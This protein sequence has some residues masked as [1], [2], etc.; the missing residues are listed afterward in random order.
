MKRI[1]TILLAALV[2]ASAVPAPAVASH[3]DET[4]SLLNDVVSSD[5][6]RLDAMM[7]MAAGMYQRTQHFFAARGDDESPSQ[8]ADN[9]KS[10][11][12][13]NSASIQTYVNDRTDASTGSDVLK[14][15]LTEGDEGSATVYL[16]A[17]VNG[18][19][20][21]NSS[22]VDSTARTV[23]EECTLEGAAA[24]NADDELETFVSTFVETGDDASKR[25]KSELAAEY[26]GQ[27]SCSFLG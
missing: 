12:N 26:A 7:G 1:T 6:D 11:F 14:L 18:S 4:E 3:E 22:I 25:Y 17:D 27:I 8:H 20:Y 9:L 10:T 16:V 19:N 21:E 24:R 23:D 13:S 2:V 15:T 5:G